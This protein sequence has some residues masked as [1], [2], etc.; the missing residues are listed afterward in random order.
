MA[1]TTF[2]DFNTNIP[3]TAAWLNDVNSVAYPQTL[4]I[5]G[6]PGASGLSSVIAPGPAGSVLQS[7]G[8]G[9]LPSFSTLTGS[10][11]VTS[12]ATTVPSFLT[13]TGSPITTSGTLA[14][15]LV[16]Q[17]ANLVFAGPPSGGPAAPTFRTLVAA[18]LTGISGL[19]PINSP[20]FTG[21]PTAPTPVHGTN[22]TQ[23]ATAA[24]VEGLGLHYN[25]TGGTSPS[26][27]TT[28]TVSDMGRWVIIGA[29]GLTHTLPL[30]STVQIGDSITFFSDPR[31]SSPSNTNGNY[32][33]IQTQSPD[34]FSP[35]GLT[36]I[37][38][39]SG[40]S[41]TFTANS[42]AWYATIDGVPSYNPHFQG[43]YAEFSMTAAS[44][45][46]N[47]IFMYRNAAYSGGSP[48]FVNTCSTIRTDVT[49]ASATAF[50]WN[51]LALLNNHANAGE[52][53]AIYAQGNRYSTGP[54]WAGV[55][56]VI[57][58]T[59]VAN[60]TTGLIGLEVDVRANGLDANFQ[61]VG[62]DVVASR[63]GGTGAGMACGYGIRLQNAADPQ[64]S[65]TIGLA[66]NAQ[67]TVGIDTKSATNMT[68]ALR[69]AGGQFIEWSGTNDIRFNGTLGAGGGSIGTWMSVTI[70]GNQYWLPLYH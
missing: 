68:A 21:T 25:I 5:L 61:R 48:G 4:G 44:N 7:N 64:G 55:C 54:T 22:N 11:T 57:D 32:F 40:E 15:G 33:S 6:S 58:R 66:I 41:V 29:V 36:S 12:V 50:E 8:P 53:V 46:V 70:D 42:N 38:F 13:V 27:N 19:A 34:T 16:N 24:Y 23:I 39:R 20:N 30:L 43:N 26:V 31:S 51:L 1:S 63:Q 2:Q 47:N 3:I 62:V 49:G 14:I 60:P 45:D 69:M 37:L 65:F 59:A 18:D 9:L 56:E 35:S 28:F 52:N 67:C 17:N 10:G